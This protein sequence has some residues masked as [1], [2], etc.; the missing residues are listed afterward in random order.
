MGARYQNALYARLATG[1]DLPALFGA[2]LQR[3]VGPATTSFTKAQFELPSDNIIRAAI[4]TL[5][6][7]QSANPWITI[8]PDGDF[9]A[10]TQAKVQEA[11]YAKEFERTGFYQQIFHPCRLDSYI[12]GDG[13]NL[14]DVARKAIR[15]RR[16]LR[17]EI[18]VDEVEASKGKPTSIIISLLE[19]RD[20][21]MAEHEDD[22][23][24]VDA[25]ERAPSAFQG[26][27][28]AGADL[29]DIVQTYLCIKLPDPKG[30]HGRRTLALREHIIDDEEWTRPRFPLS[31]LPCFTQPLGYWSMGVAEAGWDYQLEVNRCMAV[32]VEA[33]RHG[34]IGTILAQNDSH[35]STKQLA[36]RLQQRIVRYDGV[37]PKF[38][39]PP[40]VSQEIY[41]YRREIKQDFF[42]A[43]GI[44]PES[45]GGTH[46]DRLTS[47]RA[48][49]TSEQVHD[50]RNVNL[51]KHAEDFI[52]DVAD[53][54]YE[55]AK[56]AAL[57]IETPEGKLD[58]A[59]TSMGA[60]G[61]RRRAFP[62]SS[63]PT[64]P[65]GRQQRIATW[66]ANGFISRAEAFRLEDVPDTERFVSMATAVQ[67]ELEW[68]IGKIVKEDHYYPPE[69]YDIVGPEGLATALRT[70]NARYHYEKRRKAPQSVLRKLRDFM[71]ALA[72][73]AE[74][75]AALPVGAAGPLATP[76]AAGPTP[77]AGAP[78]PS[79][80]QASPDVAPPA[81]MPRAA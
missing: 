15:Y 54:T 11:W 73:Q 51:G 61:I 3:R 4:D 30:K 74:N 50:L 13:F 34:A 49:I 39:A 10:Y 71:A 81:Q 37:E 33:Q 52:T 25:I 38:I 70:V 80:T 46:D 41:A 60:G 77:N 42:L 64:E 9:E 48:I 67:D 36:S 18:L 35:V 40:A 23:D 56:E 57:V 5:M 26:M 29:A 58:W 17:D 63:L 76:T 62:I 45:A 14:T 28:F 79:P 7:R 43:L 20:D 27:S 1:R 59:D 75:P 72:D 22:Q 24:T 44:S 32:I 78:A 16:I 21:L 8:V 69:V 47:G 2:W 65:A 31:R 55:A 19:N 6:N 12:W 66:Y 68:T 53:C